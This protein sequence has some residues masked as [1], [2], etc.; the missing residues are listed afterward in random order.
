MDLNPGFTFQPTTPAV[1]TAPPA[2]A[3]G[4]PST[5]PP[6]IPPPELGALAGLI[7]SW[8][9]SGFNAIWRPNQPATGSDR[10]LELNLTTE[11][12]E[13]DPIPGTIPNR[14]LLQGDLFMAGL[15]YLQQ[16][17]DSNVSDPTTNKNAGLHIEPGLWL[18]IP[19]TTDP[20]IPASVARLAAIPH[21]TTVVAQGLIQTAAGAP[22]IKPVSITPF[23]IG[24]PQSPVTFP[25]QT[26]T[27]STNFR[28]VPP[29]LN[30]ISQAMLDNPNS[31]L[32]QATAGVSVS[33]TTTL[34]VSSVGT[35]VL[36]G[37]TASTAFL[38]GGPDGPNADAARVDSTFWL[39]TAQGSPQPDLLQ[40]SQ[41]VLLNFNGL[42]W[43]H[44]TVG[45]LRRRPAP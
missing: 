23:S 4:P 11:I 28:T 6:S 40:Y 2:A 19:A 27:S 36:G 30:G 20:I 7:G 1:P 39:M 5:T 15:R 38:Q 22:T 42:S 34:T 29:G 33:A 14:G 10:F 18:S 41:I 25:E 43:P 12:L 44:V 16:I 21:G 32:T 17:S 24:N 9:G 31:V 13:F 8:T 37:G 26:L 3:T 45:T 35:P